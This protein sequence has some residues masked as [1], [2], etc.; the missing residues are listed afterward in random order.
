MIILSDADLAAVAL[1]DAAIRTAVED[2]LVAQATAE[3]SAEP[4]SIFNPVPGRD[5]LIAV[6]RGAWP[7]REL[8]MIKTVGG[9]PGNAAKGLATNPGTLTLIETQTGQVTGLL[10]AARITSER[11][12]MVT[13]IGAHHLA[14]P[15]AQVLSCIG[16]AGISILATKYIARD[17]KLTEIRLHGRDPART[18]AAAQ[19]LEDDT[20]VAVR[21]TDSWAACLAGADIM[22][23][24]TALPR[25]TPLLPSAVLQP[26]ALLIVFGAYSALPDDI[27]AHVDRLVFDRW[28]PDGRG[29]LGPQTASGAV[30][31]DSVDALIGN[32]MEGACAR[33]SDTDRILF[34]HRGVAACDMTLANAYLDAAHAQGLGLE[35]TL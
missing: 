30:T 1:P 33:Q 13:A 7:A 9:F 23:D 8:A 3:A 14:R 34:C 28:V 12:A 10:P 29:G 6:I 27:M 25:N 5:D 16:T 24:G 31:E 18:Q 17:L 11:T 20:G 26:G 2:G 19:Q 21:A 35:T 15:G 4:T 22:I 32:V